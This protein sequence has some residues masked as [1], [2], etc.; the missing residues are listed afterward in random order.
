M[1]QWFWEEEQAIGARCTAIAG[2]GNWGERPLVSAL[3][4]AR[5]RGQL[6]YEKGAVVMAARRRRGESRS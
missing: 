1:G 5:A 2:G 4:L 6:V 3:W